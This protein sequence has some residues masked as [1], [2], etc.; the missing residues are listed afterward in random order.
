MTHNVFWRDC[1]DGEL[2]SCGHGL[3]GFDDCC[4]TTDLAL[5][6][7][8]SLDRSRF[9]GEVQRLKTPLYHY[10]APT[11]I[12]ET[13]ESE[14]YTHP[15]AADRVVASFCSDA[16]AA[17]D[18]HTDSDPRVSVSFREGWRDWNH[19]CISYGCESS[20][21]QWISVCIHSSDGVAV[22][23]WCRDKLMTLLCDSKHEKMH[24]R[25]PFLA[26]EF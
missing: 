16:A 24:Q 22:I 4:Q 21:G 18:S 20:R 11:P 7:S 8:G 17:V 3:G 15:L 10:C 14:C 5:R 25:S 6:L 9:T 1:L 13:T 23:G 26:R 2:G 12:K 19:L